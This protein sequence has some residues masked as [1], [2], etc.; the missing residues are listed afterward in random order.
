MPL[1]LRV[2]TRA[3]EFVGK[4]TGNV[5]GLA[6]LVDS[7]T[8]TSLTTD[9]D[10]VDEELA[11]LVAHGVP[12]HRTTVGLS[13][14]HPHVRALPDL[15]RARDRVRS[16]GITRSCWYGYGLAPASRLGWVRAGRAEHEAPRAVGAST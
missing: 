15:V 6:A 5:G 8:A 7:V 3:H 10:A 12:R 9:L 1:D 11:A 4:S 14:M 2:S 13:L 16:A